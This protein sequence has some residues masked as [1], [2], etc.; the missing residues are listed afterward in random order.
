[1]PEKDLKTLLESPR[2]KDRGGF[3]VLTQIFKADQPYDQK[4]TNVSETFKVS[5]S[6][7]IAWYT[8]FRA[9]VGLR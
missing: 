6:T 5:R 7:A 2:Y 8:R 3:K 1:M 4:I 9:L